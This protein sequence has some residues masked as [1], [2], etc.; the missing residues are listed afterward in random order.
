MASS[1][2][3]LLLES[4]DANGKVLFNITS[5]FVLN[6]DKKTCGG[7]DDVRMLLSPSE[8]YT[9]EDVRMV[10]ESNDDYSHTWITLKHSKFTS[11]HNCSFGPENKGYG[12]KGSSTQ[13]LACM[14]AVYLM[15][16]VLGL[17]N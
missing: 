15:A 1:D 13:V 11:S 17:F 16:A 2:R 10:P 8:E 4:L 9:V 14:W 12:V 6:L 3:S 5:C 7:D